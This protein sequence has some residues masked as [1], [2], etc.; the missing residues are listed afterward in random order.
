V[1]NTIGSTTGSGATGRADMPLIEQ[2]K[3]QTQQVVQQA[4]QKAGQVMDQ[5][6]DQVKSQLTGQKDRATDGLGTIAEALRRTGDQLRTQD[7]AM[8]GR[9]A[10][11]AAEAVEGFSEYLREKDVDDLVREV[12]S[13]A[14][15][16]PAVFLGSA[17]ALGF[18]AARFLKS[19]NQRA[20]A[21]STQGDGSHSQRDLDSYRVS[22]TEAPYAPGA[23]TS[24]VTYDQS[25]AV[26]TTPATAA[27]IETGQAGTGSPGG[28][29]APTLATDTALTTDTSLTAETDETADEMGEERG[30]SYTA[31]S[32][33]SGSEA[34]R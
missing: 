25:P 12:E 14:R 28:T 31:S 26:A 22:G 21:G 34:E 30:P 29:S 17:F 10:E 20:Y 27:D 16:Q 11:Q 19:S 15:R 9:Y 23:P 32:T 18:L 5:A 24:Y 1:D 2:A 7:Q 33:Y 6:R 13:F 3:E 8:V 4:G